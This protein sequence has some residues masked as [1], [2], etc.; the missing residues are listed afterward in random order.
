M[1]PRARLPRTGA[2]AALLVAAALGASSARAAHWPML[3]GT[4]EG[5]RPTAL[6]PF[7]FT[8]L[9]LESTPFAEPVDGR[10]ASFNLEEPF[11]LTLRRARFG[12]RGAVP[13]TDG[14][15]TYFLAFE[16]GQNAATR[17]RGVVVIDGSVSLHAIPGA[18]IRVGQFKL[19]VMDET[20]EA[21]PTTADFI[22]FSPLVDQLVFEH[23]VVD[24]KLVGPGSANRDIGVQ[25]F[26]SFLFG[27]LE[28]SYAAMLS[29][30][31]VGGLDIDAHK[32]VTARVQASWLPEPAQR[33]SPHRDEVSA[34]AWR[35]QGGRVVDGDDVL[36]VR[37]GVG[38]AVHLFHT[39]T[40]LEVVGGEG[41][42]FTGA[43]F[44]GAPA[45]VVPEGAAWGYAFDVAVGGRGSALAPFELAFGLDELHRL[46]G[47]APFGA[48]PRDER[49]RVFRN[50]IVGV[51]WHL[52]EHARL[53]A[54]WELRSIAT[55][56]PQTPAEARAVAAS[57]AD[58]FAVQLNATF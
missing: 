4:E 28:L 25:V 24:G 6:L 12:V 52:T 19:P 46:D 50:A 22:N 39:R 38:A 31:H 32:D 43:P 26:D 37:Q 23:T 48:A 57:I 47:G 20:L 35:S 5:R 51:M 18:R 16:A 15:V 34:W 44:P 2:L 9:R 40:R 49:A 10:M 1:A 58:V 21:N 30:G 54:N 8:Q 13:Q 14:L 42:L 56:S 11:E 45:V 17:D 36:R 29:Q 7:G 41:A 55:P 27:H 53:L 33:W 3:L